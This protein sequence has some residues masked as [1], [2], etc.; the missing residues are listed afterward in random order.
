MFQTQLRKAKEKNAMR[1]LIWMIPAVLFFCMPARAQE[2][3]WWELSGGYSH[4]FANVGDNSF[5]LH[6]GSGAIQENMNDWFGGRVAISAFATDTNGVHVTAQT[7]TL[8]PVFSYRRWERFTPFGQVQL[9]AIHAS[10]GFNGIS[11]SSTKFMVGPGGGVDVGINPR[12][13]V[14]LQGQYVTTNFL[15]TRQNNFQFSAELVVRLGHK[16]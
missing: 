16:K 5:D 13:A 9:G 6:G 11:E 2:T 1:R 14:R 15:N 4:F 3:P 8:A 12:F 7:Y 10:E